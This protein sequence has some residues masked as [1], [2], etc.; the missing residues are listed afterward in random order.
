MISRFI[1]IAFV[2]SLILFSFPVSG[3]TEDKITPNLDSVSTVNIEPINPS[4]SPDGAWQVDNIGIIRVEGNGTYEVI[5]YVDGAVSWTG[6]IQLP[7]DFKTTFRGL[8]EGAHSIKFE[9]E[10][11]LGNTIDKS[12]IINVKH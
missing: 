7:Y 5:Y 12:F 3:K 1:S 11:K 10:D 9:L 6:K 2:I 4:L 8:K